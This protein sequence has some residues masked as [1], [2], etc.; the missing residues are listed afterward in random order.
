M[1][2]RLEDTVLSFLTPF[3]EDFSVTS[4]VGTLKRLLIHSPDSSLGKVVPS[5]AQ[6]WLFEDIVH[7]DTVRRKE[8]D[9]YIKILLFFLDPEKVKGKIH[10]IDAESA[11]REFYK[12]G[13]SGYFNS[14]K[15]IELQTLLT[16]I[17]HDSSI[18]STLVASTCAI[19]GCTFETQHDLLT[20]SP[21]DLTK[22]FISGMM[23]DDK[24]IFAP[25][26]N[27]IFTRDIGVVINDFVLLNKPAK[28]ART[29]EALL[30]KYIFYN[31]PFFKGLKNNIIELKETNHHFLLPKDGDE[32]KVTLEGGDVMTVSKDH[33]LVG[34]SERTSM[35][36]AHQVVTTLF[37]RNV[38]SKI[39]IVKI[40]KKRD[41]MHIDTVFT[42][43]KRDTWVMLGNFSRKAIK[44]EGEDAVQ[45]IL[46]PAKKEDELK[47]IQFSKTSLERPVYFESLEDLLVNIS[48][49][50]LGV[51]G[52]VK[53]IFS[54][55]N[56]FPYDAREQWTDSC[57]LLALK[58]GVVLGYDR[59]DKTLDAF[60]EN[61]FTIIHAH[62]FIDQV[63][64]NVID[65]KTIQDTIITMPSAELSRARGG[66]HCMSMPILRDE[67]N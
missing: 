31:H 54:G 28:K 1:G 59:N 43:V 44:H 15:V 41:Y 10:Q 30:V 20:L 45:R 24:M 63:E 52:R 50:D 25:I 57:N 6:D 37:A 49:V 11:K 40:P 48:Q 58:E 14:D 38:V 27:F 39:T 46:E 18:K 33:L 16:D 61:G 42:Q 7:L 9:F 34:V 32:K 21:I 29:R 65:V 55:N 66:F 12:P 5:K 62:D 19:E 26:P 3:M 4:E 23:P 13:K 60:K 35:E 8:Y 36:A 53:I 2:I 67:L 64:N 17:L 51:K 47:I 22:V 56:I